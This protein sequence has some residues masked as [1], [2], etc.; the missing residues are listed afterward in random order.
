MAQQADARW[1]RA[2]Y[3]GFRFG[4]PFWNM[5]RALEF[6]VLDQFHYVEGF[7]LNGS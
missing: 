6:D 2:E 3:N 1:C 5:R 7:V 4:Q